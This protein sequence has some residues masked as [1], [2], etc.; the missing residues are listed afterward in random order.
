MPYT[1]SSAADRDADRPLCSTEEPSTHI[2]VPDNDA[3]CSPAEEQSPLDDSRCKDE[4]I[5]VAEQEQG[6]GQVI[7]GNDREEQAEIA[8][9]ISDDE[10]CESNEDDFIY[11]DTQ[12]NQKYLQLLVPIPEE[13]KLGIEWSE[14]TG[15]KI[16]R[17]YQEGTPLKVAQ[18]LTGKCIFICCD[19]TW[20]NAAGTRYPVTNVGRLIRCLD[21]ATE[22]IKPHVVYYR[23]GVGTTATPVGN[24]YQGALGKGMWH[25]KFHLHLRR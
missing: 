18:K 5:G 4:R 25:H 19:G 21:T 16:N 13:G 15:P 1:E 8:Q 23:S 7:D 20:N 6:T 12:T 9:K 11:R 24:Y 14:A 17:S 2:A 10:E 3:G 22:N